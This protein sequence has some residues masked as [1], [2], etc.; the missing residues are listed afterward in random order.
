MIISGTYI[1][2]IPG[3]RLALEFSLTFLPEFAS[4]TTSYTKGYDAIVS[5]HRVFTE[6][7]T[8][9]PL[10]QEAEL[11]IVKASGVRAYHLA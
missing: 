6:R 2:K 11:F 9:N 4:A 7:I 5:D 3:P 8:V 10:I 1:C